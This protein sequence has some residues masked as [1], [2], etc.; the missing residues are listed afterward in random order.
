MGKEKTRCEWPGQDPLYIKYHDEEWGAPTHDDQELFE[1]LILEGQQAGL[2]WITILKKRENFR[3]ALDGFD[4]EKMARYGDQKRTELQQNAGI[5]RNKLKIQSF[6]KNA[7]GFLNIQKEFGSFDRYL[8][9]FVKGKPLQNSW[10]TLSDIPGNT[11]LAQKLS[12][13]L[14]KRGFTFVGP[15]ICYAYMQSTG[16]VNDHIMSCFRYQELKS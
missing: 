11:P 7:Q 15:T 9:N 12:K 8:W 13:D 6:T 14:K 16:M 5:I 3:A 4:P 2:S 1:M 10:Q